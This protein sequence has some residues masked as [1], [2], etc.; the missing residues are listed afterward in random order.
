MIVL[1]ILV[2]AIWLV[3]I[4]LRGKFWACLDTDFDSPRVL[5]S[6]PS[7]VA[8][9]PARDEAALIAKS[10]GSLLAQEYGGDFHVVLVDDQ[11]SDGTADIARALPGA[12]IL[13]VID[14]AAPPPGWTGKVWAMEQGFRAAREKFAPRFV[15]FTDADIFHQPD[16]LRMLVA[17]AEADAI[18][19]TSLMPLLRCE[20]IAEKFLVPAY[21][22]FFQMLY[23]FRWA[24]DARKRTAAAAG[25]CMLVRPDLLMTAG[26]LESFK[27]ALIDDCALALRMKT[28]GP[29]WLGLTKRVRSLR[30]S[31]KIGDIGRT[32]ARSAYAQ[33]K[34]SPARLAATLAGMALAFLAPVWLALTAPG[35]AGLLGALALGLMIASFMPINRFY[36]LNRAWAALLPLIAGVYMVY[37]VRSAL[38]DRRGRDGIGKGE[39]QGRAGKGQA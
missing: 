34:F 14:G 32:I 25:G 7:V 33:L 39:A 36:G 10:L 22:Y 20:S 27:G 9:V 21:V 31:P 11:S 19:L 28:V 1:G 4:F 29:V 23:P 16:S 6:W 15:L 3:L 35:T 37:T 26:G 5:T 18:G 17:R 8:I 30:P 24:C 38:D 2:L 13:T 12:E